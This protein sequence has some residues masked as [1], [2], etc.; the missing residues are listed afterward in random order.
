MRDF[1]LE[2]KDTLKFIVNYHSYGNMFVLPYSGDYETPKLTADQSLIYSEILTEASF[3]PNMLS[4]SA[5]D[6]VGYSANGEASDW[7]LFNAGVVAVSPE[8]S[9]ASAM[10]L[11]FD[12]PSVREEAEVI[13]ENMGLPTYLLEKA[14]AKLEVT[15]VDDMP[16]QIQF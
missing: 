15:P 3:P 6:L 14:S 10:S 9:S 8:L 7:A 12:I 2:N 13:M 5:I 1:I 11:T 16:V 4:G